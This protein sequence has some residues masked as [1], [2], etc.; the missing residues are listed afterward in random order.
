MRFDAHGL[1]VLDREECLKL[2]ASVPLGRVVF[3]DRALPA[4]QPV[5]FV[6]DGDDV[7]ICTARGSRL[8]M[9]L[10]SSVV[11]FEADRFDELTRDGWSVTVIGQTRLVDDP[12]DLKH[13]MDLPLQRWTPGPQGRFV[14]I[15]AE[16]VSGRRIHPVSPVPDGRAA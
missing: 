6:L 15:S 10:R 5:D 13:L 2:L 11:A 14:R 12:D 16:C 4:I 9:A 7:V 8:G 3:T 1:E